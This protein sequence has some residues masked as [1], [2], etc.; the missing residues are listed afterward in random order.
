MTDAGVARL[1]APCLA[2]DIDATMIDGALVPPDG[3]VHYRERLLVRDP[4]VEFITSTVAMRKCVAGNERVRFLGVGCAG[5]M[6]RGGEGVSLVSI[7]VWRNFP[8]R[9]H[10]MATMVYSDD[11]EIRQSGLGSDGPILGAA[12]V[13]SWGKTP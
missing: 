9:A 3:S 8:S 7:A 5:P 2:L 6:K 10:P 12:L 11:L 4:G 1:A 13:G